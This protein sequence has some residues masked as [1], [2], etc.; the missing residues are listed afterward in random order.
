MKL[1][2]QQISRKCYNRSWC[3]CVKAYNKIRVHVQY[4]YIYN[5]ELITRF[6]GYNIS[7]D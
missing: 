1:K 2:N 3:V 5:N 7:T 4:I 6:Q